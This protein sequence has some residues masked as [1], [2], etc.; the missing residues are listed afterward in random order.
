MTQNAPR[1]TFSDNLLASAASAV[2]WAMLH[3]VGK[4]SRLDVVYGPGSREYL[5]SGKPVIYAFWHR[6]QFL[7]VYSHRGQGIRPLISRSRDGELIARSTERMGFRPIRGSSS[8]GGAAALLEVINSVRAGERVSFTPDGPKGPFR[9]VHPGVIAAARKTGA[10]LQPLAWAGTRVK[11]FA[12]WDRFLVPKPFGRLV[13][14]S[15]S[16]V[17]IGKDDADPEGKVRAALDFAH[18]EAERLLRAR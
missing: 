12:S 17:F 18:A 6:F 2:A 9:S 4:T 10:P 11:E 13:V 15:G 5:D 8:R 16:P 1:L 3:S 7:L 14:Y